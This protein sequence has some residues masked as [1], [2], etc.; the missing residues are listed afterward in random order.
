MSNDEKSESFLQRILN[1]TTSFIQGLQEKLE[2][3][4][5]EK[6]NKSNR[7][8]YAKSC[9]RNADDSKDPPILKIRLKYLGA[10]TISEKSDSKADM[11]PHIL[12]TYRLLD[13]SLIQVF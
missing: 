1:G 7:K 11:A 4:E 10:G 9:S 12:E 2:E 3:R 13:N 8:A 6:T 5:A